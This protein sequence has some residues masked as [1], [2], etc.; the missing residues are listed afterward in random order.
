MLS[1]PSRRRGPSSQ[2]IQLLSRLQEHC[3]KGKVPGSEEV[4]DIALQSGATLDPTP[5]AVS[6]TF[7]RLLEVCC[8]VRSISRGARVSSRCC[9]CVS[10]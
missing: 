6:P 9:A 7:L 3:I 10:L 1:M 2:L 5:D 8:M 4:L